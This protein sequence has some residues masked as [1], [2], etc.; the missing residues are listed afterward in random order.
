MK[1]FDTL[2]KIIQYDGKGNS[3]I[4]TNIMARASLI[5]DVANNPLVFYK[6]DIQDGDTPEIVAHKYYGDSYRY[7]IVLYVNNKLDPQWDWPLSGQNFNAYIA[8]KYSEVDPYT[9]VHNYQK[10]IT[11]YDSGTNT[12]TVNTV[13]IDED[14]YNSLVPSTNTYPL[15]TGSVTVSIEG[16]VVSVYDYELDLNESKRKIMIL[17]NTYVRQ[18]ESEFKKLMN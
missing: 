12:T 6:Y 13:E 15:P 1:Y 17:N 16:K 7:W 18:F 10:V 5:P 9:T 2:P 14:T 3:K 11:Q 8:D 4:L